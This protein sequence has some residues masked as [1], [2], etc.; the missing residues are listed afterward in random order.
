MIR[1]YRLQAIKDVGLELTPQVRRLSTLN[2]GSTIH[3]CNSLIRPEIYQ[4]GTEVTDKLAQ[5][6]PE[7]RDR[8]GARPEFGPGPHMKGVFN[9]RS[10]S[11]Q[12]PHMAAASGH[13]D[14]AVLYY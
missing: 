4:Y 8:A 14:L 11:L 1:N 2:K 3:V 7:V 10:Q 13:G 9:K 5:A 12:Q 6:W